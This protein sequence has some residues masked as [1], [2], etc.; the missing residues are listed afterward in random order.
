MLP[1]SVVLLGELEEA[2]SLHQAVLLLPPSLH[3]SVALSEHRVS[4]L[5]ENISLLC[6]DQFHCFH[7]SPMSTGRSSKPCSFFPPPLLSYAYFHFIL[8]LS[9]FCYKSLHLP[10]GI[11]IAWGWRFSKET[12]WRVFSLNVVPCHTL[13]PIQPHALHLTGTW[14]H[15]IPSSVLYSLRSHTFLILV[16]VLGL[17]EDGLFKEKQPKINLGVCTSRKP[18]QVDSFAVYT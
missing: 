13:M 10:A 18:H 7:S 17:E 16:E 12:I 4:D 9:Y 15:K 6:V 3:C 2:Q 5:F 8:Q 11:R 14:F 1:R